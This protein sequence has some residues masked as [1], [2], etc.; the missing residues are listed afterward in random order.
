MAAVRAHEQDIGQPMHAYAFLLDS[1]V[2][3]SLHKRRAAL[4]LHKRR[5]LSKAGDHSRPLQY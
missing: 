5:A 2:A 3:L 4:T 1:P